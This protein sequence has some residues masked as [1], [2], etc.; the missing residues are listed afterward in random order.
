VDAPVA[1]RAY[2]VE[3]PFIFAPSFLLAEQ[4]DATG[5]L[6]EGKALG[7]AELHDLSLLRD[8]VHAKDTDPAAFA[9]ARDVGGRVGWRKYAQVKERTE[10]GLLDLLR[11]WEQRDIAEQDFRKRVTRLMKQAWRDV[12]LAGIRASGTPPSGLRGKGDPLVVL[13]PRDD[14]WLRSAVQH[15]MR[16]LNKFLDAAVSEDFVMPLDRRARMYVA[17][18][19][20]FYDSAR[21]IGLP[22]NSAVHWIGVGDGRTCVS[23]LFLQEHSPYTP[24]TLP[25]APRSGLQLCLVNDRCWL[26]IRRVTTMQAQ[27]IVEGAK[28]T[29]DGFVRKLRKIKRTGHP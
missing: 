28:Y 27:R 22:N 20:A 26:Y 19:D 5:T 13:A 18:L 21:I 25:T 9:R 11:Q 17:A 29:R 6:L 24:E 23:C 15:E 14:N 3:A 16:F 12:F 2:R 8:L 10:A 7:T 1:D 4:A